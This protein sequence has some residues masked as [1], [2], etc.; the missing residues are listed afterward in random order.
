[1]C[2]LTCGIKVTQ[3]H[4]NVVELVLCQLG[5]VQHGTPDSEHGSGQGLR[6]QPGQRGHAGEVDAPQLGPRARHAGE[7]RRHLLLGH[8]VPL[9]VN[10]G[11][12]DHGLG[13][14]VRT[15]TFVPAI[16]TEVQ[17]EQV[18][19][20]THL[21]EQIAQHALRNASVTQID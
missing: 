11:Q 6:L 1:M 9:E 20:H 15:D 19:V 13:K 3:C 7:E 17:R 2:S 12:A 18:G 8:S 14:Q 5:G 21:L 10:G 4:E 16:M